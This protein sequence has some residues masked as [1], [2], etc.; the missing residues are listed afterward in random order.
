[1]S[2]II[3]VNPDG[4]IVGINQISTGD[5][6]GTFEMSMVAD[7]HFGQRAENMK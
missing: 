5:G 2:L 3:V 4:T 6:S 7:I 1:M